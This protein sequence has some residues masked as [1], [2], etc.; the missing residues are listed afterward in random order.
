MPTAYGGGLMT[1]NGA[2]N[3]PAAYGLAGLMGSTFSFPVRVPPK[4]SAP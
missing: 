1:R 2:Q 4:R 3:R